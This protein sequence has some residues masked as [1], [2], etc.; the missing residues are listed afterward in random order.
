[1][2]KHI[3]LAMPIMDALEYSVNACAKCVYL[4]SCETPNRYCTHYIDAVL[5]GEEPKPLKQKEARDGVV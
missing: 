3:N 5:R 1:M 2:P 4:D